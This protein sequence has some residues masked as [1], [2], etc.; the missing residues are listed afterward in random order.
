MSK[1]WSSPNIWNTGTAVGFPSWPTAVIVTRWC[2]GSIVAPSAVTT[3]TPPGPVAVSQPP[4]TPLVP[5]RS[6]VSGTLVLAPAGTVT[7]VATATSG[8]V[9]LSARVTGDVPLL[10]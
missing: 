3:R 9:A 10:R 7:L 6:R 2:G 4:S 8:M 1:R 5:V